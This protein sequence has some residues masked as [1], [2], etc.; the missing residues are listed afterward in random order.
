MGSRNVRILRKGSDLLGNEP[1]KEINGFP[2]MEKGFECGPVAVFRGLK[3]NGWTGTY[4]EMLQRWGWA[5]SGNSVDNMRDTPGAHYNLLDRLGVP[6]Q[7]VEGEQVARGEV[8]PD[9]TIVLWHFPDDKK[10]LAPEDLLY[11]H[12]IV[13]SGH[14]PEGIGFHWGT[15]RVKVVTLEEFRHGYSDAEPACAYVIGWKPRKETRW[16][17]IAKV[18]DKILSWIVKNLPKSLKK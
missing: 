7:V 3:N 2:V 8:P 6:Y 11:Q 13:Y 14:R 1:V 17:M 12:W 18:A 10:T 16:D 5:N 4:E 9:R 15:G